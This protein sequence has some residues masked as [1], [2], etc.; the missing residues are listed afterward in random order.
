MCQSSCVGFSF[1]HA[2]LLVCA[3]PQTQLRWIPPTWYPVHIPKSPLKETY[4]AHPYVLVKIR[5]NSARSHYAEY[6]FNMTHFKFWMLSYS[7][8]QL[9]VSVHVN[10]ILSSSLNT[11]RL[12]WRIAW[13]VNTN[14][15]VDMINSYITALE[16]KRGFSLGG[17]VWNTWHIGEWPWELNINLKLGW[18]RAFRRTHESA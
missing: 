8:L 12:I 9:N 18:W 2:S 4:L 6:A 1:G 17:T 16:N 5:P 7:H 11:V 10:H 15:S 14:E 3:G 13:R